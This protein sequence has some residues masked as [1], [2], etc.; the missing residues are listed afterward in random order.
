M[1]GIVTA[2][3]IGAMVASTSVPSVADTE[4]DIDVVPGEFLVRS[5]SVVTAAME[6]LSNDWFLLHESAG[7]VPEGRAATLSRQMGTLVIPNRIVYLADDPMVADQWALENTG[8]TGGVVD[9]DL[10]ATAA[11]SYTEGDPAVVIAVIDTGV[12]LDHPDLVDRLWVN[13]GEIPGNGIDDDSNGYVDD[14]NGWDLPANDNSPDDTYGHGTAVAGV[15]VA[16]RNGLG[17]V[18]LAPS[19]TLMPIRACSPGCPIST[20]VAAVAYARDNGADIINLSLGG[21]GPFFEPLADEIAASPNSLITAAAGNT[22]SNTDSNPFYPA[23][24]DLPNILSVASTDDADLMSTFSSYGPSVVDLAAPGDEVLSTSIGGW[25]NAS[26]TSF[27]S[28]YA[29]GTA[30]LILSLRREARPEEVI[31]L[32]LSHVDRLPSLTGKVASGGRLNAGS[33]VYRATA[34]VVDLAYT[35][36]NLT[37]PATVTLDGSGSY[38]PYGSIMSFRWDVDGTFVSDGQSIEFEVTDPDAHV[39]TLTLVDDD[40][41]QTTGTK[42]VDL[43]GA[44]TMTIS[45]S[46]TIAVAP[47]MLSLASTITDP[48][49]DLVEV[50]WTVDGFP[51]DPAVGYLSDSG[52]YQVRGVATDGTVTT[53]SDPVLM[54]VG[55]RFVDTESSVFAQDITWASAVGL[56]AGCGADRFCPKQ[57]M[58]RGEAAAFLRRWLLLPPGPDAFSDDNGNRFESDINALAGADITFGC[59]PM[60]FCPS[61][62]VSRGQWAALVRRA[63][64][65]PDGLDRFADD[66]G[67][68]FESDINALAAGGLTRGCNP[69]A[70]DH[71][72][73]I[74]QVTRAEAVAMLH[75]AEIHR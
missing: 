51:F 21:H 60:R 35:R 42:I 52:V 46:P 33:A 10:D 15:A 57:P 74:R 53:E 5:P 36:S 64:K 75:R 29:A 70:T 67:S 37:Y 31:D 14:V 39:V 23:G 38:D 3:L 48:D 7:S 17:I 2:V 12:D 61:E 27:A 58:T 1:R 8:Q 40:G 16:S 11:W 26:G 18:G 62:L 41:L 30:A 66:E 13:H 45:V 19:V 69:P 50:A 59:G 44:P 54:Y 9:A 25:A 72:C 20:L 22:G 4:T 28:P 63:L 47:V 6:P 71:Y 56:T 55:L 65:L 49:N 43:N 68:V 73:P 34:P 32:I 24:F